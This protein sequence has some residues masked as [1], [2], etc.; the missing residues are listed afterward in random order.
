VT[1]EKLGICLVLLLLVAVLAYA[2][3]IWPTPFTY[4]TVN[5]SGISV[6]FPDGERLVLARDLIRVSRFSGK[7]ALLRSDGSWREINST[8]WELLIH[9]ARANF[10]PSF[11]RATPH[12]R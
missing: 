11:T 6:A 3:F 5:V 8:E 10:G 9:V 4:A 2:S 12:E 1:S 7:R